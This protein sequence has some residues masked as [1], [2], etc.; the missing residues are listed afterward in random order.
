[1]ESKDSKVCMFE[2]A[3]IRKV[4]MAKD[5]YEPCEVTLWKRYP[6][7]EPCEDSFALVDAVASSWTL[8]QESRPQLCVEIGSGSGYVSCSISSILSDLRC[9]A[10]ILATDISFKAAVATRETLGTHKVA[11][12]DVVCTDLFGALLPN[13]HG[14]VDLL[15]FNPPYVPTPD[16]EVPDTAAGAYGAD[17]GIRAA[18]AGGYRGRR[19]IDRLLPLVDRVLSPAGHFFMVT[20]LE[21]EPE[22]ILESFRGRGF[23]GRVALERGADEERLKVLH[24]ARQR[25]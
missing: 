2:L 3:D 9:S 16:D 17:D 15:V 24:I 6:N 12:V 19:V 21:N 11:N 7:I 18:W 8:L 4:S 23:H 1:M 5:V 25:L 13:L 14:R 10:Q 20:V 22:E